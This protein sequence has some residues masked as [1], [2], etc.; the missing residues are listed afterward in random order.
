MRV[1]IPL[2]LFLALAVSGGVWWYGTRY[3][4]FLTPPSA[5]KL[6][7]IRASLESSLPQADHPDDAVSVPAIVKNP[8]PAAPVEEPK[9]AMV[10][11]DLATPPTLREYSD[12]APKGAGHLINL[13]VLLE[14]EGE[15][16]RALLAWER[17]LDM[18]KPDE[19]QATAAIASIKRLRPTLPDWNTHPA[20]AI[21]IT[22]HAGTGKK[23]AT[24]L[25]PILE[26][27]ARDLERASAGI[28]KVTATVTAGRSNSSA[29]SAAPVALWLAGPTKHSLSTKVLSFTLT[30]PKSLHDDLLKSVFLIVRSDLGHATSHTPPALAKND[31]LLEALNSRITRLDWH[32]LG[33]RLNRP[34]VKDE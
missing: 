30:S 32:E 29:S 19:A 14:V 31:N 21:A 15:F 26:Q 12:L 4:D 28:L 13:A 9:P 20:K 7:E 5:A 2:V 6:A 11:G 3:A 1:P 8:P 16:H 33:T 18:G 27:T 25:A 22:L 34:P 23:S 17:A 24:T 10:L